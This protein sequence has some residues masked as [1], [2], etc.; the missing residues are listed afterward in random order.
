MLRKTLP[1]EEI[2]EFVSHLLNLLIDL[3]DTGE[4]HVTWRMY[5]EEYSLVVGQAGVLVLPRA[6]M[7]ME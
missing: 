6:L 2:C 4:D 7:L 3:E 5:E 1:R